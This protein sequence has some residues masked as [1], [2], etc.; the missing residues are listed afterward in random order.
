MKVNEDVLRAADSGEKL[1]DDGFTT[2]TAVTREQTEGLTRQLNRL[3]ERARNREN[4]LETMLDK[5]QDFQQN[6]TVVM[7]DIVHV[8]NITTAIF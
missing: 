6:H 3:D 2:D 1:V 4:D 8:S 7:D 5:L